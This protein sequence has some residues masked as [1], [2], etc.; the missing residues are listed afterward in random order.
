[1]YSFAVLDDEANG[2]SANDRP[3][4][5]SEGSNAAI[6]GANWVG[7]AVE[8]PAT[9]FISR[10]ANNASISALFATAGL[11]TG[12]EGGWLGIGGAVRPFIVSANARSENGSAAE[13][14]GLGS[15]GGV[16]GMLGGFFGTGGGAWVGVLTSGCITVGDSAT[17]AMS[18][19]GR[20]SSV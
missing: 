1:L 4:K 7:V 8:G 16:L 17:T 20:P 10:L 11:M 15:T 18:G 12:I 6:G 19:G 14:A 13:T 3:A 2:E 5:G 9:A